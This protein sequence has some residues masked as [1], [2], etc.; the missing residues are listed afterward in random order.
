MNRQMLVLAALWATTTAMADVVASDKHGFS[1][2]HEAR[3]AA[4]ASALWQALT[5]DVGAWWHPDHTFSG[6]ASKLTLDARPLGCF[7]EDLGNGDSVVHLTVTFVKANEMLR[8]T[9]ALGPLGVLG[10]DGNMTISL[11]PGDTVTTVRLDYVVGGYAPDGLDALASAVDYVLT[12]QMTRFVRYVETGA[13]T[14][15]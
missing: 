2:R 15:S 4:P 9:G 6:D 5:Q 3:T 8:L 11:L 13:P 10:V 12:E 7:C 14:A 1:V